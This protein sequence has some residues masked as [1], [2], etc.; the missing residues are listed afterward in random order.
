MSVSSATSATTT[1]AATTTGTST[2]TGST[3]TGGGSGLTQVSG[4]VSGIDSAS[5]IDS[6]ITA[7]R[8]PTTQLES[9]KA[10]AQAH[11]DA[12]RS[13][14][15]KLLSAQL[16]FSNLNHAST[17]QNRVVTSSSTAVSA[18]ADSSAQPGTYQV[19]VV[20]VAT[21][22][23]VA[24][25]GLSSSNTLLGAGTISLQV[26]SGA[27]ST[28]TVD[29]ANSNLTGIAAAINAANL[30]VSAAVLNDGTANPNRLV[31]TSTTTGLASTVTVSGTGGLSGLFSGTTTVSPAADAQVQIGS[32]AGAITITQSTNTFSG[33]V[34]GVSFTATQPASNL[35]LT[36]GND[37]TA[38]K[39]AITSFVTS[40][41]TA[42]QYLT[43]NATYDTTTNQSG[44]LFTD[45]DVLQDFNDI[46]AA[47]TGPVTGAVSGYGSLQA[48]GIAIDQDTGQ[49]TVSDAT[50]TAALAADPDAVG[51]LFTNSGTSS[52]AGVAFSTLSSKTKITG[53]LTVNI[54]TAAAQAVVGSSALSGPVDVTSANNALNITING[55]SY[56]LTLTSGTYTPAQLASHLASV[57]NSAAVAA[58]NS[59]DQVTVGS[60]PDGSLD[61]RSKFFGFSQ[62]IDIDP[63][64]DSLSALQ[65][66]SGTVR[67]EDV[68]GTINGVAGTGQGQALSA[69]AGSDLDGLRLFV[70]AGAPVGNVI[71]TVS[72]GMAQKASDAIQQLTD[73]QSGVIGQDMDSLNSQ[74]TDMTDRITASDA[75]LAIRRQRLQAQFDAMEQLIATTKSQGDF[76][77]QQIKGFSSNSSA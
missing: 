55:N 36:V 27:T 22:N 24:T 15:L 73:G 32:G 9:K 72:R 62:T 51:K 39:A 29:Q 57:I 66:F 59:G 28:V 67:G 44:I 47:L 10:I 50:L 18:T 53:P 60:N 45:N 8:I 17:F 30:G 65:L 7:A 13:L 4:L 75:A 11:V 6:L 52:N 48:I 23:Q 20:A 1:P 35:V 12:L 46:T 25:A 68:A 63:A 61:L 26:G 2:G 37:A 77:T 41:N 76:L 34:P 43:D 21:A 16:D 38:A 54:T 31:L 49:L 33:V 19:N 40:Y 64:S 74:I 42:K 56:A 14:N 70:S 71:V 5:I 58:G 3:S 69:A